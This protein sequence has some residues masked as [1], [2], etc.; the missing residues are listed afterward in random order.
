MKIKTGR[1]VHSLGC[2]IYGNK[3]KG[4]FVF[5]N[6]FQI[7]LFVAF[8]SIVREIK[9]SCALDSLPKTKG[10]CVLDSGYAYLTPTVILISNVQTSNERSASMKVY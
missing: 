7:S 9:Y 1:K 6:Y 3:A 5:Q 4:T 8:S 2:P 10:N